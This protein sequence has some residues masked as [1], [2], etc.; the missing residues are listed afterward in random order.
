MIK[1]LLPPAGMFAGT[2]AGNGAAATPE[3]G[4]DAAGDAAAAARAIVAESDAAE[5]APAVGRGAEPTEVAL[6]DAAG[7]GGTLFPVGST[8]V[9][10]HCTQNLAPGWVS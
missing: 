8:R 5:G 3:G 9:V 4:R 7:G 6:G 1:P 10:P 2:A